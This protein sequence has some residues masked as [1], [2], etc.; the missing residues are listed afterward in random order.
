MPLQEPAMSLDRRRCLLGLASLGLGLHGPGAAGSTLRPALM[1]ARDAPERFDPRGWLVSEKLDGVR[2]HWDGQVLRFRSGGRIAAPGWFTAALPAM[3]LDG[4]LWAGRGRFE[5]LVGTVRRHRPDD[6]A[7]RG[8]RYALFDAPGAP[9][10][11]AERA[12]RLQ[13]GATHVLAVGQ[14]TLDGPVALQRHLDRVV[15]QGGE[16][17]M[18][19]RASAR[20]RPGRSADLL[21][22]KPLADAEA[23]VV[24]HE[25]GQGRHAGRLGALSVQAPDGRR[26]RLGTGFSDAERETPPPLGSMVTYTYRGFTEAGLPR[27]ASF[28]RVR[29][30]P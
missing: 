11:F 27:F 19:H 14:A 20:W 30:L 15:A 24:G 22:L 3:P 17:L 4:E 5:A 12:S 8:V 21:K 26:F 13:A 9:G 25:P 28:V 1:E 7:W 10:P 18:L 6:T 16:G 2:A 23:V 29:R